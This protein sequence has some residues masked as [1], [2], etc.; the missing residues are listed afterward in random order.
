MKVYRYVIR[1]LNLI[2]VTIISWQFL[3]LINTNYVHANENN[4]N[5]EINENLQNHGNTKE[6]YYSY[7]YLKGNKYNLTPNDYRKTNSPNN[8]ITIGEYKSVL[9]EKVTNNFKDVNQ[10]NDIDVNNLSSLGGKIW[11]DINGNGIQEDN[12]TLIEGIEVNL[13]DENKNTI[14]VTETDAF[15]RYEF[16]NLNK[17]IYYIKVNKSDEFNLAIKNKDNSDE[18]NIF[19][20]DGCSSKI[21]IKDTIENYDIDLAMIKPISISGFVWNDINWDNKKSENEYGISKMLVKLYKDG[22]L[23]S[24]TITDLNGK[25]YFDNLN[26]GKYKLKFFDL[27]NA[28]VPTT[29][30]SITN[31]IDKDNFTKS[32]MLLSGDNKDD[33]NV[34]F[35]RAK[36][37]S[38]VFRDNNFNGIQDADE[39]GIKSVT[40]NLYSEDGEF[41]KQTKTNDLGIYEFDNL[42]PGKYYIEVEKV[43][44]CDKF[45]P[46]K[47]DTLLNGSSVNKDGISSIFNIEKGQQYIYLNAGIS[48]VGNIKVKV[49][50]DVNYTGKYDENDKLLKGTRVKLLSSNGDVAKD[51]YG[52]YVK[53]Q[54]SDEDGN[55]KFE[56]LPKGEYKINA[57]IPKGYSSFTKQNTNIK[58]SFSN[59]NTGGYSENI[60]IETLDKYDSIKVGVIKSGNIGNKVW[61]DDNKNGKQ[62]NDEKGV[63]GIDVFLCDSNGKLLSVTKTDNNGNYNFTDLD[64]GKYYVMFETPKNLGTT[65][66][67]D[68]GLQ[69]H[70]SR[71]I[72]LSS[73]E[74]DN[75]INLG[76]YIKPDLSKEVK[77]L[78]VTSKKGSD[79]VLV[80]S[81]LIIVGLAILIYKRIRYKK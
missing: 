73:G 70:K 60:N 48:F 66:L 23:F 32:Y 39:R 54:F 36:I 58:S 12:E 79:Y 22:E 57:I 29:E 27:K 64:P 24:K 67:K 26:P 76:V 56:N 35:H 63:E 9:L 37:K 14:D 45:S 2:L 68:N 74:T 80:G 77:K 7:P 61:Y 30:D 42:L 52:N 40:V 75:S 6:L 41:I 46:K 3:Q 34:A 31:I 43:K 59:V 17:G 10:D 5:I 50:E 1:W 53:D 78:P 65:N 81:I 33:I 15:G 28:Y 16:D 49:F 38:R 25:Y 13:L 51:V 62:D 72:N 18:D 69:T 47:S 21:E 8:S 44:D 11:N 20:E 55:V 4:K 19:S 71:D